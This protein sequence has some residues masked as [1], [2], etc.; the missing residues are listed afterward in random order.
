[1]DYT[2]I[3]EAVKQEV[4][5]SCD[6]YRD[7]SEDKYDV[8]ENHLVYALDEGKKLS[9]QYN[10]NE[11]IVTLG[12]LLHD[13]A[14]IKKVGDREEH[15]INGAKIAKEMLEKYGM[16]PIYIERVSGCV[17]N[18][19]RG[20]FSH[21]I[22]ERCVSDAD[23]SSHFRNLP[24]LFN[25][26]YQKEKM[27]IPEGKERVKFFLKEDYNDLTEESKSLYKEDYIKIFKV[28]FNEE[29]DFSEDKG[30]EVPFIWS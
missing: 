28:V 25:F 26:A 20:I 5:A 21:N 1:M 27:S 17:F 10:A 30:F 12:I 16:D 3:I 18:H 6:K 4:K 29:P 15:H 13:I 8:W 23:I 14:V 11:Q 22:E 2:N 24:M 9:Q 19:R 7:E